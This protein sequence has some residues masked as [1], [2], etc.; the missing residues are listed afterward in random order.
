MEILV[1][2]MVVITI[3]EHNQYLPP[4]DPNQLDRTMTSQCPL[5]LRE[6]MMWEDDK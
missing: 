5:L 1:E 3:R 6:E 2:E 4:A